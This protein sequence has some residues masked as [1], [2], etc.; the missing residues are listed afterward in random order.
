MPKTAKNKHYTIMSRNLKTLL[1]GGILKYQGRDYKIAADFS[2]T[3]GLPA[4]PGR[5]AVS[6]YHIDKIDNKLLYVL[7]FGKGKNENATF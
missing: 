2:V 7:L 1:N 3:E 4:V 6:Y 5:S